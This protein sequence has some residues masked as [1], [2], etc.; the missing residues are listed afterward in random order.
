MHEGYICSL[1]LVLGDVAKRGF[2]YLKEVGFS[3]QRFGGRLVM[4]YTCIG[5]A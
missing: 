4:V 2:D 5:F 3:A 1:V